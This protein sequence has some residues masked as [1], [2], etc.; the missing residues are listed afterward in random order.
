MS[1]CAFVFVSVGR[2]NIVVFGQ[3]CRLQENSRQTLLMDVL[4]AQLPELMVLL[5]SL[6]GM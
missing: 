5:T 3:P 2:Y 1:F 4:S 6:F